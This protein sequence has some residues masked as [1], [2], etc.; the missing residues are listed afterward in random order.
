M[1]LQELRATDLDAMYAV[2]APA[3]S[4]RLSLASVH[5]VHAVLNK[6]LNDAE[7]KGL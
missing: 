2:A 1:P 4:A 3:A 6:M 5:H 7:R